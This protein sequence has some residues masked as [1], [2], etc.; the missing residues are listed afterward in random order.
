MS[1]EKQFRQF[2]KKWRQGKYKSLVQG[3]CAG[4]A[5]AGIVFLGVY[6]F[7]GK[8]AE[9]D[10]DALRQI[11]NTALEQGDAD[12]SLVLKDGGEVSGQYQELFLQNPD[13][14]GWL[15][16][17]GTKV[18]YPVMWTPENPEY[19]SDKGFDKKDSKNGLLFMDKYSSLSGD[20]GNVIIYG[21]NMKNGS[22]FADLLKYEEKSYF[23]EHGTIQFDTLTETRMYEIS[24]VLKSDD[25]SELPFGFTSSGGEAEEIIGQMQENSLYDTGVAMEYGDDFL[26]LATCDYSTED[27]RL[28]IM[29]VRVE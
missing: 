5:C 12:S 7:Q 10:I 3:A 14:I 9:D 26:T 13:L 16:I 27:G 19:Y 15:T 28:V 18:D 6:F 23:E 21:H 17:D 24:A 2:Q 11:K 20:G 22:M 25:L 4:A 29:A 1:Y 8:Q